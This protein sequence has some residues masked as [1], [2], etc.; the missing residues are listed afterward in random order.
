MTYS[1]YCMPYDGSDGN[2]KIKAPS[3]CGYRG[4]KY[5]IQ[6][7]KCMRRRIG[8]NNRNYETNI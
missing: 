5:G 2:R 8:D 4:R 1:G 6:W 3:A 7:I